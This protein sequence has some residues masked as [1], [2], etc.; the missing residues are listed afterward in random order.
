MGELRF[1]QIQ[2][3][4]SRPYKSKGGAWLGR[5]WGMKDPLEKEFIKVGHDCIYAAEG[6]GDDG[7]SRSYFDALRDSVQEPRSPAR[8]RIASE[9]GRITWTT[10]TCLPTSLGTRNH[11]TTTGTQYCQ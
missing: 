9:H 7:Y 2:N 10:A 8:S 4:C 1:Y 3:I 6:G 5:E 11:S